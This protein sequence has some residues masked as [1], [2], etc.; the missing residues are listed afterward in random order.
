MSHLKRK[1]KKTKTLQMMQV[2]PKATP[3]RRATQ[4]SQ[5]TP[6]ADGPTD[7]RAVALREAIDQ[8]FERMA[9]GRA[10][11][12]FYGEAWDML[13]SFVDAD[14]NLDLKGLCKSMRSEPLA[15]F[16]EDYLNWLIIEARNDTNLVSRLQ[17]VSEACLKR[18]AP[19]F[20]RLRDEARSAFIRSLDWRG[21]RAYAERE[22]ARWV[23]EAPT[24]ARA[25]LSWSALHFETC[26]VVQPEDDLERGRA[27]LEQGL[28]HVSDLR[29]RESLLSELSN[30]L[31]HLGH[32]EQANLARDEAMAIHRTLCFGQPLPESS[33]T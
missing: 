22:L 30:L 2:R 21:D 6:N 18:L 24:C 9:E 20:P 10:R 26:C 23:R 14:P 5:P 4:T 33:F 29:G 32:W 25:W 1:T 3:P 13:M 28:R 8:G 27:I 16:V 31:L 17:V 15:V 12:G 7:P 19:A 11:D